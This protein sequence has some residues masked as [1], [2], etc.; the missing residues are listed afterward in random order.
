MSPDVDEPHASALRQLLGGNSDIFSDRPGLTDIAEHGISLTTEKPVRRKPY[1]VPYSKV[2]DIE[3]EVRKMMKLGVIEPSRSPYCSPLM[4]VKKSDG[5]FR[6]EIDFRQ[7]NRVT[8]FDSEPMPN[9]ETIFARLAHDK[10][11]F[12]FDVCKGYW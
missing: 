2:G 12:T 8:V 7:I 9:P 11:F 4:L 1:P 10:V 3:T 6:P 5:T